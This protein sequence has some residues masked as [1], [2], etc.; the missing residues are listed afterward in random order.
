MAASITRETTTLY[1]CPDGRL[2]RHLWRSLAN[3]IEP[4]SDQASISDLSNY[5]KCRAQ[6]NMVKNMLND[7]TGMEAA[8]PNS[9]ENMQD[10]I[11]STN[12]LQEINR[13]EGET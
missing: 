5:R 12:E 6:K 1:V 2:Y 11:S 8:N 3:K 13:A 7:S 4:E 10:L 9:G